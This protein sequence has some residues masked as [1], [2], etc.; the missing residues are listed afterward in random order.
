MNPLSLDGR[1]AWGEG[2]PATGRGFIPRGDRRSW[3]TPCTTPTEERTR[4]KQ[5]IVI[6]LQVNGEAYE[7]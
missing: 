2:D 6:E 4:V 3:A 7:L 5:R 1:G